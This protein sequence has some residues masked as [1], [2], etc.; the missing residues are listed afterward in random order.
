MI[1]FMIKYIKENRVTALIDV[2][3]LLGI[4]AL[5]Y[6]IITLGAIILQ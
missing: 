4:F 5:T 1:K 6:G 3:F 2:L